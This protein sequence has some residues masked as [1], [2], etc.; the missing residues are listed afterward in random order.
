MKIGIFGG[1][2]DPVHLGHMEVAALAKSYLNLDK[3]IFVP[4]GC[5]QL[6]QLLPSATGKQRLEMVKI[7]TGDNDRFNTSD[8]EINRKGP[9]FTIDTL[10]E[11]K[12]MLPLGTQLWLIVGADAFKEFN[13]WE[14]YND[15]LKLARI[16]VIRREG[17]D[18][19]NEEFN[20]LKKLA[21]E[22]NVVFINKITQHISSTK[23]KK[24]IKQKEKVKKY[25]NPKVH[26][27]IVSNGLYKTVKD[28]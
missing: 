13:K 3:V 10:K 23:I 8:L 5:P 16:C 24:I 20:H 21:F 1:T 25:L 26:D 15:I 14:N 17:L 27:Y 7:A 22:N 9:T 28:K 4:A 6:K 12:E 19:G 11:M 18:M 2:F